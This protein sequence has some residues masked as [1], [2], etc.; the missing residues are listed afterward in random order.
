M[1]RV[2]KGVECRQACRSAVGN[3]VAIGSCR[4]AVLIEP[5]GLTIE[6]VYKT[7]EGLRIANRVGWA[8]VWHVFVIDTVRDP[9][10]EVALTSDER[11]AL[12][13]GIGEK[14]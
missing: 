7:C 6:G 2:A 12:N 8:D 9:R 13:Y 1:V 11:P 3:L 14:L 4:H 5:G 10:N